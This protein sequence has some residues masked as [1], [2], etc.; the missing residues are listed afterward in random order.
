MKECKQRII[1]NAIPDMTPYDFF[2][3]YCYPANVEPCEGGSN[4]S[5]KFDSMY[6]LYVDLESHY[7]RGNWENDT[8]LIWI[9]YRLANLAPRTLS[10]A[11]EAAMHERQHS[12]HWEVA[13]EFYGNPF[14][15]GQ[16]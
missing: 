4:Y 13:I 14:K 8:W 11:I 7:G 12:P 10:Q 15:K 16:S 3:R 6:E 5:K 9:H 1:E 2:V